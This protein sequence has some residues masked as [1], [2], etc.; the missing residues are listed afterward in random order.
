MSCLENLE[1]V[2]EEVESRNCEHLQLVD[3]AGRRR[4]CREVEPPWAEGS[5]SGLGHLVDWRKMERS[6]TMLGII[7]RVSSIC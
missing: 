4:D 2:R 3:T 1:V 5:E 6:G 7:F